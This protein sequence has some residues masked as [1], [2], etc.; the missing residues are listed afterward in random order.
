MKR[1]L[2]M[3]LAFML[4]V[5]A[6]A[7]VLAVDGA[8]I[9][10]NVTEVRNASTAASITTVGGSFTTLVLNVTSQTLRWKAYVG[11]VT[12]K[13]T[14]DDSTNKTIYDWTPAQI[15][16]EIYATRASSIDWTKISCADQTIIESEQSYLNMNDSS[17]RINRTFNLTIHRTFFVGI[18]QIMNSSCPAIAT[19]IN[20]TA[21][22]PS[23]DANFQEV[24]LNSTTNLIYTGILEPGTPGFDLNAYNF[25]LILPE[26]GTKSTP[27][28]YYFY[29]ELT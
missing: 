28:P 18:T 25:Q 24:L 17:D 13:I 27:T 1:T 10:Q 21:Q 26:D 16:G 3:L 7:P 8:S 23:E 2:T 29:V 9:V 20:D 15:A 12:G 5:P 22:A 4:L 19:Y 6:L 14:L 11:N